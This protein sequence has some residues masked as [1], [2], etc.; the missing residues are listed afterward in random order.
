MS[1]R[2]I[3]GKQRVG[4]KL[5]AGKNMRVRIR[6]TAVVCLCI[7]ACMFE[8]PQQGFLVRCTEIS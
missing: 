5:I 4:G 3:K 8:L 2:K 6:I 1:S 7:Y